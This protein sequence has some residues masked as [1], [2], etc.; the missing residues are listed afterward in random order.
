M[1]PNLGQLFAR[2]ILDP[3]FDRAQVAHSIPRDREVTVRSWE[4]T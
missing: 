2:S 3:V 1:R 4:Q